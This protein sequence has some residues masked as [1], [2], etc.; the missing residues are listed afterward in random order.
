MEGERHLYGLSETRGVSQPERNIGATSISQCFDDPWEMYCMLTFPHELAHSF[1]A[2]HI[3]ENR[4]RD[5]YLMTRVNPGKDVPI[6]PNNLKLS[7]ESMIQIDIYMPN[8]EITFV[9][10]FSKCRKCPIN[11]SLLIS[12]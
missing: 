9:K 8:V 1:G 10:A 2:D 6:G 7:Q 12:L 4:T 3:E 5:S 11:V